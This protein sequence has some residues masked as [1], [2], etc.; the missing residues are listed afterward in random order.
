M[1][2]VVFRSRFERTFKKLDHKIQGLIL[3]ELDRLARDPFRHPQV[4][5]IAGVKQKAFRLRV[6]RW[7]VVYLILT[8]ELILEV[9]DLFLRQGK[10]YRDLKIKHSPSLF[11]LGGQGGAD[12]HR[13]Y[14]VAARQ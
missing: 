10:D 5:A 1:Y 6:G 7:R 8:K 3:D 14:V 4:R 13:R 2:E 9:I 12:G 11:G